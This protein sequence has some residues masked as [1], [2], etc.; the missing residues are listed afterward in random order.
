MAFI[1]YQKGFPDIENYVEK[2]H[3]ALLLDS[4]SVQFNLKIDIY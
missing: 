2:L 1:Y 4:H 3:V